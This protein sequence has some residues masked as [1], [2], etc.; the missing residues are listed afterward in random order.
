MARKTRSPED[1]D[2]GKTRV[3]RAT[4]AAKAS[5]SGEGS[6]SGS[7][8][9]AK[10]FEPGDQGV[11][12][13]P[14]PKAARS[15]KKK[16]G[17]QQAVSPDASL[18][19]SQAGEA[20]TAVARASFPTTISLPA[21]PPDVVA[22]T[23][24]ETLPRRALTPGATRSLDSVQRRATDTY[25]ITVIPGAAARA[26]ATTEFPVAPKLR[27]KARHRMHRLLIVAACVLVAAT[28]ITVIPL[29]KGSNGG[30]LA[31]WLAGARAYAIPTATPTPRPVYPTHPVVAGEHAF[32]CV[33]LPL[34]RLAQQEQSSAGMHPWYVSVI[35]AQW[36]I[37]QGWTM[38]AYTGYNFG[39][40][41]AIA[42]YP[43][44]GG[45][46]SPGSPSAFAY[47]YTPVQGV[48]YYVT[49]TKM[50]FYTGVTAAWPKGPIGQ[51][52]ALGESPWDAAHYTASG[53]PGS[54]LVGVID[55]FGLERFDSAGAKC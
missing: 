52:V 17:K 39:N 23:K 6:Q 53:S 40:V 46:N 4:R 12:T 55:V 54:S 5:G 3:T 34:A 45:V 37:E 36:G 26:T 14:S 16:T 25:P 11:G 22:A 29:A 1:D 9:V 43:S 38:P 42:G 20:T 28:L 41:S 47:A 7:S 30:P 21:I 50:H 35:L 24:I 44:I 51:A 48:F 18:S 49:Y 31:F 33:A 27:P 15:S 32:V 13:E 8:S 10:L 2:T 19:G